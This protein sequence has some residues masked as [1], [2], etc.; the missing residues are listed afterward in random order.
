MNVTGLYL[1]QTADL[2]TGLTLR[3]LNASSGHHTGL[4]FGLGQMI[5]LYQVKGW[6]QELRGVCV[7]QLTRILLTNKNAEF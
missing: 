2:W 1:R 5:L 4:S 7:D 6:W 3:S